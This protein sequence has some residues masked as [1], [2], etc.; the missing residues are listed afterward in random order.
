MGGV[1]NAVWPAPIVKALSVG[2][3]EGAGLH[4]IAASLQSPS[5][6]FV[7]L[8]TTDMGVPDFSSMSDKQRSE[9]LKLCGLQE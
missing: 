4:N 3:E 2:V 1:P 8:P 5:P 6:E 9:F 7:G